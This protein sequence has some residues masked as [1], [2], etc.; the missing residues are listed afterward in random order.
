MTPLGPCIA[1]GVDPS[2][3]AIEGWVDGEKRQVSNTNQ[4]IFPV[5]N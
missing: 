1:I 2:N 5:P 4:L 3:L